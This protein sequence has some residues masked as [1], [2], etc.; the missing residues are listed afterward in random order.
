MSPGPV[1]VTQDESLPDLSIVSTGGTIASRID[2]RTGAVTSQFDAED[3]L[4]AIPRLVTI[5]RYRAR[6]LY[7]ILSE[8][9]TPAI[10]QELAE[11]VYKEIQSGA[12]RGTCHPWDRYDGIQCCGPEFHD[13]HAGAGHICRITAVS[14]PPEQR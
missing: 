8:N 3:I 12:D 11:A 13:R 2:Y 6:K 4:R 10:W 1:R 9:M 7:T 14:R 5:G